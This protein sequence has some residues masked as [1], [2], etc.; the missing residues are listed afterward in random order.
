MVDLYSMKNRDNIESYMNR[1]RNLPESIKQTLTDSATADYI[2]ETIAPH[3]SLEEEQVT[4]LTRIIRDI[5]LGDLFI[6]D[7]STNISQKLNVDQQVTQQIQEKMINDLFANAIEDIKK[8]QREKF[9]DR[10]G[11]RSG[12]SSPQP[13]NMKNIPPVNQSNIIDLRNN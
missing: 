6:G 5:L 4:E 11:Q 3:F 13:P 1:V 9:P 10:V 2:I 12:T 8:I 7:M